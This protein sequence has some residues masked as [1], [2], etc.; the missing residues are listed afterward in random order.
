MAVTVAVRPEKILLSRAPFSETE[1]VFAG[2]IEDTIYAGTDTHYL[3]R[4]TPSVLMR[5]SQQNLAN[6][7]IRRG[8]RVYLRWPIESVRLLTEC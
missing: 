8:E 5:V 1:N 6:N 2:T 3:V 4:L 7:T